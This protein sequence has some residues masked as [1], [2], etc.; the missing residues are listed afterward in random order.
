MKKRTTLLLLLLTLRLT[1]YAQTYQYVNAKELNLRDSPSGKAPILGHTSAPYA[2]EVLEVMPNG[3]SKIQVFDHV[4]Y[5][6]NKFLVA[7]LDEVTEATA[8]EM[9]SQVAAP[10]TMLFV[11]TASPTL[12]GVLASH[13]ASVTPPSRTKSTSYVYVCDS[14]N[15]VK[16]HA[17][18]SCR[19]LNRCRAAVVKYPYSEASAKHDPCQICY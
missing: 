15:T 19:G 16:Y 12:P 7:T 14:G 2:V 13:S 9:M 18:S 4:G 17:S 10:R 6:S 1:T 11:K 8:D 5:A 3:W